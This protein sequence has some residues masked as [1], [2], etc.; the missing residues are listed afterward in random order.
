MDGGARPRSVADRVAMGG[1]A[2][3]VVITGGIRGGPLSHGPDAL[4]ESCDARRFQPVGPG[5]VRELRSLICVHDV[6]CPD[7]VDGFIQ[8]LDTEGLLDFYLSGS[9][10]AGSAA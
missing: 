9:Q 4:N 7:A 6:Q 5:E 8:R 3:G 2:P 10:G 1:P